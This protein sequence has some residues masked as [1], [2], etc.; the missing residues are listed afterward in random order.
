MEKLSPELMAMAAQLAE[1]HRI[2]D[3]PYVHPKVLV[4]N[5]DGTV[6]TFMTGK[7]RE[8]HYVPYCMKTSDCMRVR[9]T[10]WGFQCPSCGNKMNYDLRHFNGNEGVVYDNDGPPALTLAQWNT[11]VAMRKQLKQEKKR[12]R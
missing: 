1:R 8:P 3:S 7:L 2:P 12:T 10:E 11:Q 4:M 5:R 6:D 9:R